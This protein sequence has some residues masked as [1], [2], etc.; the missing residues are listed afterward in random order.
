M[1]SILNQLPPRDPVKSLK[2]YLDEQQDR[3]KNYSAI[4]QASYLLSLL[5]RIIV[6]AQNKKNTGSP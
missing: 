3:T 6:S 5:K 2:K 1:T 4:Q